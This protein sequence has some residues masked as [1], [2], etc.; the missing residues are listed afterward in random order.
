MGQWAAAVREMP[1]P[2][3]KQSNVGTDQNAV[4]STTKWATSL[5]LEPSGRKDP[6]GA[7]VSAALCLPA[8]LIPPSLSRVLSSREDLD[9]YSGRRQSVLARFQYR[10]RLQAAACPPSFAARKF[11]TRKS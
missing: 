3:P 8:S 10:A 6:Y 1:V 5:R 2:V 9:K 4:R 7:P 11:S